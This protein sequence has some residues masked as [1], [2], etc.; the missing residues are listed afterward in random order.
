MTDITENM[1]KEHSVVRQ[2]LQNVRNLL[3]EPL[4]DKHV[5]VPITTK[6]F[7]SGTLKPPIKDKQEQVLV[8][9]AHSNLVELDRSQAINYL[10]RRIESLLTKTTAGVAADGESS[11]EA[12]TALPFFEIREELDQDGR[13]VKAEAINVAKQLEFLRK[14]GMKAAPSILSAASIKEEMII[15]N[16]PEKLTTIMDQEYEALSLRLDELARLE[17]EAESAKVE[18]RIS[19]K[20]LQSKGWSKGFLNAKTKKK[21][22]QPRR[23][24]ATETGLST[25]ANEGRKVEFKSND[26]IREIPRIGERSSSELKPSASRNAIEPQVFSG[27]IRE[28]TIGS[29]TVETSPSTKA[30]RKKLSRFA[31]ERQ[32]Q[33]I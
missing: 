18:N 29:V 32:E 6:A 5:M 3:E 25:P 31:Q 17:E 23:V 16:E 14:E 10:D 24:V 9:M 19:S 13:E 27:I 7:F 22:A 20:K 4:S 21:K 30:P 11:V 1:T 26:E 8:K 12:E 28:R 33:Q 15:D 2:E